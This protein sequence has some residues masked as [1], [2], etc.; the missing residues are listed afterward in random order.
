MTV[1]FVAV[2]VWAFLPR[3]RRAHDEAAQSIFRN[4]SKPVADRPAPGDGQGA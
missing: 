1:F 2:V 4:D 3:N